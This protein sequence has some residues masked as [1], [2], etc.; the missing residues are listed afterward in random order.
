LLAV[1]AFLLVVSTSDAGQEASA[2]VDAAFHAFWAAKSPR[3]AAQK[4]EE[5][6]ASGVTFDAAWARLET[7]RPYAPQRSGVVLLT[8]KTRGIDHHFA[9]NVPAGYDPSKK[10]QVRLQLHG[11]TGGR[12]DN[13]P[14]GDGTIGSL[15]GNPEQ[16]YV[17]PYAWRD[18]P[19]WSEDQALNLTVIVDQLKRAYN[20]DENRVVVAGVSDGGTGAYYMAMRE[21]TP[22]ASFLPL[23]G[24]IMVLANERI[25]DGG[26][27][28]N[29]LRNKPLFVVNG[30]LDRLYP[31]SITEPY[32]TH[33]METGVTIDYHPQES[34]EH[35]TVWWPEI[36]GPFE[37]FVAAHPRD[38]FPDTLTW[39]A[40][41]DGRHTRAHWVRID[42]W[43]TR[44]SE[45]AHLPDVN[46]A[47]ELDGFFDA[48]RPSGRVDLVRRGNQIEALTR[49]VAAFTLL[50]SPDQFDFNRPITVDVNGR[51]VFEGRVER[52]LATLLKWAA[53]DNDRTMLFGAELQIPVPAGR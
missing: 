13:Q 37:T 27:Y 4:I 30:G 1:V 49:G 32:T 18:A 34:G 17:L 40:A 47:T 3:E 51:R 14:R 21:M 38:P 29:N 43:G 9:V 53:E 15:G 50:L 22:F 52:S 16:I 8:N 6:A 36:K 20:V 19:W 12:P 41:V 28:P 10:Y 31:T 2:P 24:Y 5:I 7:G 25:D 39:T 11:G 45:P 42:Q 33:L 35:N 48:S 23:N 44:G 26:N 46:D